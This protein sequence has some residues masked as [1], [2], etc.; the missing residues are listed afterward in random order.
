MARSGGFNLPVPKAV[1]REVYMTLLCPPHPPSA[2][3][4]I[5][6][7]FEATRILA[8]RLLHKPSTRDLN[9]RPLIVLTTENV[10]PHQIRLLEADGAIVRPVSAMPPP[11]GTDPSRVNRQ[12]KDQ[13]TKL[14]LWNMTEY[15]RVLYIDA[16]ILPIRPLSPVFETPLSFDRGGEP[17][18]FAA[19]YD[20]AWVRDFGRY[21]RPM[22]VLGPQDTDASDAFNAG[23]FLVHPSLKQADY[24]KS[25]YDNPIA[26]VDFTNGMEQDLLRYA[27]RD[28]GEYP[29]TRLSQIYN[30]QWP[31]LA[32]LDASHALHDKMWKDD[33][34]V[35]WDLRQFWYVAWGEMLGWSNA[36]AKDLGTYQ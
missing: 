32:D 20:S 27:Y 11:K 3:D 29:W 17:Y 5:D 34:S 14:K 23:M 28:T 9:G 25:I 12:W 30:T 33:T 22:P 36:R 19:A 31:R 26:G 15:S 6:F 4:N 35:Q 10:S 24:I 1:H 2:D 8:Y 21:S 13:Y 18:L 7:Y 16:D